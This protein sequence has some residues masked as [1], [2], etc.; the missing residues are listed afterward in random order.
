MQRNW[1]LSVVVATVVAVCTDAS[2]SLSAG[3]KPRVT[4]Q[5]EIWARDPKVHETVREDMS[6]GKPRSGLRPP[7]KTSHVLPEYPKEAV[8]Q[9]IVGRIVV[10]GIIDA[11][12]GHPRDLEA[13]EGPEILAE[14][15]LKAAR[16]W[17]YRPLEIDKVKY[18][19]EL[20]AEITF[21]LD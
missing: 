18:D 11:R 3:R 13:T 1:A 20:K 9:G 10:K 2:P 16:R 6:D 21:A 14:A 17:R 4:C 7:A 19:L 5:E 15:A 12:N 8:K